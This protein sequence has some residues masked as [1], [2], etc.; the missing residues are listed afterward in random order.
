MSAR[1]WLAITLSSLVLLLQPPPTSANTVSDRALVSNLQ[2]P[3]LDF[4][5]LDTC[6]I[7]SSPGGY[8]LR[9]NLKAGWDCINIRSGNVI[10][11]CDGKQIE[12]TEFMGKGVLVESHGEGGMTP[13]EHVEIKNC[14]ITRFQ[15]GIEVEAGRDIRLHDND[16]SSN[17]DDTRGS[18]HGAWLGLVD[19]GGIRVNETEAS[20]IERN[21]AT[22]GANGIDI[23]DS[24]Q[25]TVRGNLASSN[26][27]FGIALTHSSDSVIEGN[28]V[29]DN[30]R[31]CTFPGEQGEVVVPG[32][33]SAGVMLQDGSSRNVVRY[34]SISGQNGDGIFVRN[35]TGRCG[36]DNTVVNNDVTGAIWNGLEAGFCDG[37]TVS[38]NDFSQS[39]FGVW[40]SYMD[41]IILQNNRLAGMEQAGAV[42]KNSHHALVKNNV[43]EGSGEGL[44]L[45]WDAADQGR[46]WTLPHPFSYYRSFAN[47]VTGN[48]FTQLAASAIH[49]QDSTANQIAAN[50]FDGVGV[51]YRLDGDTGSNLFAP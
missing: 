19:G 3:T 8:R 21:V 7:I 35:H 15:Y 36:N 31:W 16:V 40:I 10:L 50:R 20:I 25:V 17:F 13:P 34:N 43:F 51:P 1:L 29:N 33:D 12:G 37:L 26:S 4:S 2:S 38:G 18:Y 9:Q 44:V 39:K 22:H 46:G 30:V 6:T 41:R 28:T 49:L 48:S 11:D 27:A 5:P 47:V 42:I 24:R 14:R 32:C 23:R 45:L